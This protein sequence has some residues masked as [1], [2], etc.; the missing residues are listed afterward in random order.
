MVKINWCFADNWLFFTAD[1]LAQLV[2]WSL[3][4][5]D[6]GFTFLRPSSDADLFMSRT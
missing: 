3:T 6:G 5:V 2:E 4:G 1:G